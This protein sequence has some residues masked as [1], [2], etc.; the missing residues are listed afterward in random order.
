MMPDDVH[1][2]LTSGADVITSGNHIW[3]KKEIL[4]VLDSEERLLRPA[5]YP[6]GVPGHGFCILEKK[7]QRVAVMNLLGRSRMGFN[8]LCPFQTGK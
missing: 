3:Q 7:R 4:P 1:R 8:G 5:N 6:P 2:L